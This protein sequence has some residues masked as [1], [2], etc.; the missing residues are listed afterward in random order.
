MDRAED[1]VLE[2]VEHF[3]RE[4]EKAGIRLTAAYLYGS[5][6]GGSARPDSDIDVA[7]VSEDFTGDWLED[8][9]RILS[10]LLQSDSRIEPVR[11]RPEEF[12]NEHPLA[13][14]IR[15]KGRRLR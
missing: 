3:L 13:W 6:A 9:R 5:Y 4:L 7:L 1:Q 15:T 10:A 12:C 11:F 14:E 8:H 2:I